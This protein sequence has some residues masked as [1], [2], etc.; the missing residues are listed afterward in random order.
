MFH[1]LLL[2][3]STLAASNA[4]YFHIAET[5]KKCFIEEIPDETMVIGNYKVQLFDPNTKGY[6]DYPNIGM[7]VEVKDPEDKVILS[8]LYTSEG[9]FTFTSHLPGEHVICLYSNSTAWFSGAQLRVH[10]S[11]Q[12][13]EHAQDYEQIATKDK[14]NELQLRIRQLL[15]QVEQ[16]TKEQNYQRYREERFRQTSE[17]TNQRVLW[18]SVGQTLVL[19]LT[20]AWQMRHL[21][22]FFEAKKLDIL[23][24]FEDVFECE[25]LLFPQNPWQL[26]ALSKVS[27]RRGLLVF[28]VSDLPTDCTIFGSSSTQ[29]GSKYELNENLEGKTYVVTG[30]T[31]G[32]GQATVEE[33]AKR[34]ARVIMACRNREKCIQVRRDIVLSTRNKQVY[35][36]QCDLEDFDSIRAFV[37]KLCKGKF[38][39]DRIDGLI[40]GRTMDKSSFFFFQE[41]IER[42]LATNHL[43]S[44]L[45][46]GLLLD[47]LLAQDHPVRIV[48][49]NTN[50][51]GRKC[52][53]DFDD[54]N[55]ESR[56]KYDGFE[57]YKQSKLAAAMFARELSER[58]KAS[59]WANDVWRKHRERKEQP[60]CDPVEDAEK[61]RRLW[62]TSEVWTRLGDRMNQMR[63]ELGEAA[64]SMQKIPEANEQPAGGRSWTRLW[65]W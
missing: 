55:A 47:K 53:L 37:Q 52:E 19:V 30:A 50:I 8:K 48:F 13:G 43:G 24:M 59:E 62:N 18:W 23:N 57:V 51:I 5:E 49:L 4:L 33:L 64:V 39:L 36:R 14:L 22:G 12:A 40:D 21:K 6:G 29:S 28:L 16:I 44:F 63:A 25:A 60:W 65:L 10:L 32:I 26:G 11:I 45:L 38:E 31:S 42:T 1:Q 15:D 3:V 35:C 41:G 9:K 54:L 34:N 20:G 46:T 17:S 61:R 7:H 27:R 56:K 58:L 2:L